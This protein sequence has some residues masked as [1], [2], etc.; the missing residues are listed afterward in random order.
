MSGKSNNQTQAV[1]EPV[2]DFK[3]L[4]KD[5]QLMLSVMKPLLKDHTTGKYI[6]FATDTYEENGGY[7]HKE[8]QMFPDFVRSIIM[9]GIL[10]PRIQKTAVQQKLRTRWKAEV[11]TPSWICNKM[12]NFCDTEWFGRENVFN[13]ENEDYTWT[14]NESLIEFPKS[15]SKRVVP[16]QEYVE[17]R[18][19]EITCGEAPFLSRIQAENSS[20][21]KRELEFW[22]EN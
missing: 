20:Q 18:R 13:V 1:S 9:N 2:S 19:I 16:W 10:L 5:G 14:V 22:I 15:R 11:F 8:R 4:F 6:V 21:F 3:D 17:S 7:Y 12:N